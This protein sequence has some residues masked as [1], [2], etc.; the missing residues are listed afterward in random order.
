M[1]SVGWSFVEIASRLLERDEREAVLGDL[2]EA[3]E[4][5]GQSLLDVFGLVI[6]RQAILWK[7]WRPWLAAFG[8]TLPGSFLLMGISLSV[9]WRYLH[10]IGLKASPANELTAWPGF[11]LLAGQVLLLTGLAWTS[12]FVVGALSRRTLWTSAALCFSPCLFCLAR[13]RTESLSRLSLLLFLLP[14][15]WGVR[16]GLRRM[17]IRL[18]P[19]IGLALVITTL[20]ILAWSS[21]GLWFAN[22]L[23]IWPAW[24]MVATAWKPDVKTVRS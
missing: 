12:G 22:W 5:A 4:N 15:L 13:F 21:S 3:G 7:S 17:Q 8:V 1:T 6:R 16:Y 18:K 11:L 24:Y 19:A 9:S 2:T 14:A 20:M 23:L 10:F